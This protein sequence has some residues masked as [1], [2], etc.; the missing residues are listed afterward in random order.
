MAFQGP[1]QGATPPG[2]P[3]EH[4]VGGYPHDMEL[5]DRVPGA[6]SRSSRNSRF[7]G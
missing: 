1:I 5:F 2:S 7:T 6:P 3:S 4:L